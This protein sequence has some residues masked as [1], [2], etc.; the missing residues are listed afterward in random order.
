M[1]GI[2]A[3]VSCFHHTHGLLLLHTPGHGSVGPHFQL[4]GGEILSSDFQPPEQ[5]QQQQLPSSPSLHNSCL[6]AQEQS[7]LSACVSC[8]SR[9]L[10]ESTGFDFRHEPN[11]FAPMMMLYR[12]EQLAGDANSTSE[13]SSSSEESSSS[14]SSP[15]IP[16]V[17]VYMHRN[18][19]YFTV[20]ISDADF[21]S[22]DRRQAIS[23]STVGA[24]TCFGCSSSSLG[25]R[26]SGWEP[27]SLR[28]EEFGHLSLSLRPSM[29]D[30]F[31]FEK[32]LLV[33][34][35][36]TSSQ[37]AGAPAEAILM[38]VSLL[39]YEKVM[40]SRRRALLLDGGGGGVD[41]SSSSGT[42]TAPPLLLPLARRFD[43]GLNERQ[44]RLLRGLQSSARKEKKKNK[45]MTTTT[46]TTTTK[47]AGESA[48][49][50]AAA[51]GDGDEDDGRDEDE[52]EDKNN[53]ERDKT[54]MSLVD[55]ARAYEQVLARQ[56]GAVAKQQQ[57]QQQQLD[58]PDFTE[59][60]SSS[61]SSSSSLPPP[62]PHPSLLHPT[63]FPPS[64][65]SR[66]SSSASERQESSSFPESPPPPLPPVRFHLGGPSP[67]DS[68]TSFA[69]LTP[70][71]KSPRGKRGSNPAKD[72][73][74][75]Q[76]QQ[77][78]QQQQPPGDER[79]KENKYDH[80]M[81]KNYITRDEQ[82]GKAKTGS[83][84]AKKA[85][86]KNEGTRRAFSWCIPECFGGGGGQRASN[87]GIIEVERFGTK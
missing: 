51:D 67:L 1:E 19:L 72:Y 30:G 71:S 33:A 74:S 25:P 12:E 37:S 28:S 7:L 43:A 40:K 50:G 17:S 59:P 42:T 21:P 39:N 35:S 55:A 29:H 52:D 32:E 18:R 83:A 6:N 87:K 47:N 60:S 34:S 31:T 24:R 23:S 22:S 3:F 84:A 26:L 69:R 11:R 68:L 86:S 2:F 70:P 80:G 66:H 53:S 36:M 63:V 10:F 82:G 48:V 44:Y 8:A 20:R 45:I 78:Q 65:A 5:Q 62:I 54:T 73:R 49:A 79:E 14:E 57:Q 4:P 61:S 58:T 77:Q 56:S 16:P 64:S 15:S 9:T 85:N 76:Q 41:Q 46:T 27:A 13:P 75:K 38:A 81:G